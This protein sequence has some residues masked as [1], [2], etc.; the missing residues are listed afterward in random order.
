MPN[1]FVFSILLTALVVGLAL[2]ENAL[3]SAF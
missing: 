3:T 2:L 1:T